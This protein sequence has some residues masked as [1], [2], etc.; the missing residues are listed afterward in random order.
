MGAFLYCIVMRM[1]GW[2][3]DNADYERSWCG[4]QVQSQ[5]IWQRGDSYDSD[6]VGNLFDASHIGINSCPLTIV[7]MRG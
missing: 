3:P 6:S 4:D 1:W 2:P 7:E 5:G